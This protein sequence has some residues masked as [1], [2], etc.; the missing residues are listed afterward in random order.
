MQNYELI[1]DFHV[2]KE[3]FFY[4]LKDIYLIFLNI[5]KYL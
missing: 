4:L 1:F 2:L 5:K 3:L